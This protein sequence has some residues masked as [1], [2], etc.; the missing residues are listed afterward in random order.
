MIYTFGDIEI[1]LLLMVKV[2]SREYYEPLMSG[3]E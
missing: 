3:S 1:G 2:S